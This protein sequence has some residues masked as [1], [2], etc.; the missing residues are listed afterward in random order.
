MNDCVATTPTPAS[1]QITSAPTAN[2]CD[3]T[4]TPMSPVT[5]SRATIE[6]VCTGRSGRGDSADCAED[7]I[8][9]SKDKNIA[10][11]IRFI[12]YSPISETSAKN[13]RLRE[14]DAL[15]GFQIEVGWRVRRKNKKPGGEERT[16]RRAD[17]S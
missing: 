10:S 3:C 17:F 2:Q 6:K 9:R 12:L 13:Y 16:R 8:P 14:L 5:G 15:E 4:A 1:P 7:A 11:A